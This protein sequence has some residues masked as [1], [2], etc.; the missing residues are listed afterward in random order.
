MEYALWLQL[1]IHSSLMLLVCQAVVW[2]LR[3]TDAAQRYRAAL[4]AFLLLMLLPAFSVALSS[5][6]VER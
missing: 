1:L 6:A 3:R 4:F 2:V 5:H